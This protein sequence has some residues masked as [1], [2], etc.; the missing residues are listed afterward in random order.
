[1]AG[2]VNKTE[3]LCPYLSLFLCHQTL[4]YEEGCLFLELLKDLMRLLKLCVSLRHLAAALSEDLDSCWEVFHWCLKSAWPGFPREGDALSAE[5]PRSCNTAD[6]LE[7]RDRG[8]RSETLDGKGL[9]KASWRCSPCP[10]TF[11]PPKKHLQGA[12]GVLD[13]AGSEEVAGIPKL[14]SQQHCEAEHTRDSVL[15]ELFGTPQP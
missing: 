12:L 1:M 7:M 5:S 2:L 10:H 14:L 4:W 13:K 6:E 3:C 9:P 15:W 8:F 11:Y